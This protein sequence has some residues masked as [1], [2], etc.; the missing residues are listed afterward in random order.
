MFW[1]ALIELDWNCVAL[2]CIA[3]NWIGMDCGIASHCITSYHIALHCI[4][5]DWIVAF[6]F[7][8]SIVG[9]S[10]GRSAGWLVIGWFLFIS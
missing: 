3:L 8:F 6:F 2:H 1:F 5:L 4:A 7:F 9:R 10:V